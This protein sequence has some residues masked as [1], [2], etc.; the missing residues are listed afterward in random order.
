MVSDYSIATA[1]PAWMLIVLPALKMRPSV[2]HARMD[3]LF[4]VLPVE[5][6]AITVSP[7]YLQ[8]RAGVMWED[9]KCAILNQLVDTLA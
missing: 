7:V 9:V 2:A 1:L 6:A 4:R 8:E 3:M 5:H